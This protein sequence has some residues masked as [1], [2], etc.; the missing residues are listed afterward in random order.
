MKAARRQRAIWQ[1]LM[2]GRFRAGQLNKGKGLWCLIGAGDVY[3]RGPIWDIMG[4][5]GINGVRCATW[6]VRG[7]SSPLQ[8]SMAGLHRLS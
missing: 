4:K 1:P 3:L 5:K 2:S 8:G 7:P 6:L